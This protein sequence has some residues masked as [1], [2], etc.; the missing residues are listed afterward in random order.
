MSDIIKNNKPLVSVF[1]PAFNH[2][3]YIHKCLDGFIMQETDFDFEVIVHDDASSDTTQKIIKEYQEKH[4]NKIRAILQKENHYSKDSLHLIKTMF[5]EAKGKYIALCEGDDYWINSK[6]L[7]NQVDFME[8]NLDYSICFHEVEVLKNDELVD[9][10]VVWGEVK[11]DSEFSDMIQFNYIHTPTVMYRNQTG[12]LRFIDG[13]EGEVLGDYTLN[14]IFSSIGKVKRLK[15]KWSV[16]RYGVGMWTGESNTLKKQR[17]SSNTLRN[18]SCFLNEHR[19]I[20]HKW[21]Q[22]ILQKP[23]YTKNNFSDF[24]K[25]E[26]TLIEVYTADELRKKVPAKVLLKALLNKLFR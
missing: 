21:Y 8:S 19:A 9:D 12:I 7:Q 14:L 17:I 13:I 10:F 2:E 25:F 4:P 5:R 6:K 15:G 26:T 20:L 1:C 3:K 23:D 22:F 16:Y 18:A 11:D 24:D